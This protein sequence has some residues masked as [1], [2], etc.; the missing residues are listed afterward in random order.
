MNLSLS[1]SIYLLAIA[2]LKKT[3]SIEFDSFLWGYKISL[4]INFIYVGFEL[5]FLFV[6]KISI[7]NML[8]AYLNITK[9]RTVNVDILKNAR[10]SGLV[11]DPYLLGIFCATSFF[12]FK[13]K[14][15][16]LYILVALYF[17][18]SRSGQVGFFF[19][20]LY[21]YGR[22]FMTNRKIVFVFLTV[23]VM[24]AGMPIILKQLNFMRGFEGNS[25][26]GQRRIEYVTFIPKIW[27]ND[28][29]I[30]NL[31]VGGAPASSGAR[32]FYSPIDSVTKSTILTNNWSIESDWSGVLLGRGVLGFIYYLFIYLLIMLRQKNR[33]LKAMALAILF[34]GIGYNY[35]L[36][37]FINCILFF[38]A[39]FNVTALNERK[40]QYA[41]I[42]NNSK[43]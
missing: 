32:F 14:L 11:W 43:L 33:T 16:R 9:V 26:G 30:L 36:A 37:I 20:F 22:F 38:A 3:N 28:D 41:S 42:C 5:V 21:Y 24:T 4:I 29:T 17:S 6:Y 25:H 39:S 31:L 2:F 27:A 18:G 40:H 35:D 7:N 13:S 34:A 12:L 10:V 1:I 23:I 15:A 8:F 19:A